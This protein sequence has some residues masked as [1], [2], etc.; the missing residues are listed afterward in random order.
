M[1]NLQLATVN[2]SNVLTA[3][4]NPVEVIEVLYRI[5]NGNWVASLSWID[6]Q[7]KLYA[8]ILESNK[9]NYML[10][11]KYRRILSILFTSKALI[12]DISHLSNL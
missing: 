9:N 4:E 1:N 7:V 5:D 10:S 8:G 3:T 6:F 2:K 11:K 12:D